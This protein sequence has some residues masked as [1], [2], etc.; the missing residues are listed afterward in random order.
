M[1]K[2]PFVSCNFAYESEES[3]KHI[4]L[5]VI[6]ALIIV[7]KVLKKLQFFALFSFPVCLV[8]AQKFLLLDR[9]FIKFAL[10]IIFIFVLSL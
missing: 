6:S 1:P 7:K 2:T 3:G 9:I 10:K 4:F 5:L 8:I